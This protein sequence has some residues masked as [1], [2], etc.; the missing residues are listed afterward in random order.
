MDKALPLLPR[1]SPHRVETK[2]SNVQMYIKYVYISHK[3]SRCFRISESRGMNGV[4]LGMA[5][6]SLGSGSG[7][8]QVGC[9][10]DRSLPERSGLDI[11]AHEGEDR[12]KTHHISLFV[13]RQFPEDL[14]AHL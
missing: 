1:D 6:F 13:L 3:C 12:R 5:R 9:I 4:C 2:P 11:K 7:S 8:G 14:L 10:E